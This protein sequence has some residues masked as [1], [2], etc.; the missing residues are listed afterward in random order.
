LGEPVAQLPQLV[1]VFHDLA[2]RL[3]VE[4]PLV[5]GQDLFRVWR[6]VLLGRLLVAAL[7]VGS[8][9]GVRARIG[10]LSLAGYDHRG[11]HGGGTECGGGA[12]DRAGG[13]RPDRVR[14]ALGGCRRVVGGGRRSLFRGGVSTAAGRRRRG[15]LRRGGRRGG[16]GRRG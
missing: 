8:L 16:G 2:Q 12:G 15:L 6:G 11:E 13:R 10:C 5:V 4:P 7:L 3:R 9:T 1:G 14:A